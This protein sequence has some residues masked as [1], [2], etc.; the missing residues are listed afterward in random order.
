MGSCRCN[1]ATDNDKRDITSKVDLGGYVTTDLPSRAD[2]A[3]SRAGSLALVGGALALDFANTAS[4]R[5][6]DHALDHLT[7]PGHVVAWAAH[8]GILDPGASAAALARLGDQG[9]AALLPSAR[10]LRETIHRIATA[11]ANGREP[12][13]AD[14]DAAAHASAQAIAAA[15][16]ARGPDGYRWTWPVDPLSLWTILGPVALSAVGLLREGDLARVKQCPGE[17][18]GW[19]F[20]DLTKNG[21]RRWCEMSVCGNRAKQRRF[22]ARRTMKAE[23]V[24]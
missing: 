3:P 14:L 15:T 8:A 2:D 10:A 1:G 24:G 5:G 21:S 7:E 9:M 4:G 12:D 19:V 16:L 13:P 22:A 6:G 23:E 17:H 11:L 20:F 18:C